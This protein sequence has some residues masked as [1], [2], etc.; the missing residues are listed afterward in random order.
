MG[1]SSLACLWDPNTN[2]RISHLAEVLSEA[3]CHCCSRKCS[4]S[5]FQ[6]VLQINPNSCQ[7]A[8]KSNDK[9]EICWDRRGRHL[10]L[11]IRDHL[12]VIR[13]CLLREERRSTTGTGSSSFYRDIGAGFTVTGHGYLSSWHP[14]SH[15]ESRIFWSGMLQPTLKYSETSSLSIPFSYSISKNSLAFCGVNFHF[16]MASSMS[17][18]HG[19]SLSYPTL[20]ST[21]VFQ[22][23]LVNTVI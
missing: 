7:E 3:A 6:A 18:F 16:S 8:F 13:F 4:N 20:S 21:P 17:P 12:N 5:A 22:P 19:Q 14:S 9:S 11:V 2:L 15:R 23:S 10:V 1:K